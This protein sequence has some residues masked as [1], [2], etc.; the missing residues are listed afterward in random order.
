M[1]CRRSA[2][3]T[4]STRM[5]PAIATIVLRT[6]S[7]WASSPL[8]NSSLSSLVSPSTIRATS[9]PNSR[10]MSPRPTEVSSTVSWSRAA[11]SVVC[12]AS[13]R[14]SRCHAIGSCSTYGSPEGGP[15]PR[16]PPRRS[17]T[18]VPRLVVGLGVVRGPSRTAVKLGGRPV[19]VRRRRG[20]GMG[21]LRLRS[22]RG[23]RQSI[24]PRVRWCP[25]SPPPSKCR[26]HRHSP[27][28]HRGD[29]SMSSRAGCRRG[30][31]GVPRC[32]YPSLTIG[33]QEE[34]HVRDGDGGMGG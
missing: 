21:S 27:K 28:L 6:F 33:A 14:R 17:G 4:N 8:R 9:L 1:L 16:G 24:D 3:L 10:S 32:S 23:G 7:A 5:S 34:R 30:C 12:P 31:A 26:R 18:R 19:S 29:D 15:G 20:R 2:S 25:R 22:A 13:A 11:V